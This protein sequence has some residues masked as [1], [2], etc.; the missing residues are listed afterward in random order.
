MSASTAERELGDKQE[1][2]P[3]ELPAVQPCLQRVG[4]ARHLH[5]QHDIVDDQLADIE[6]DDR[7]QRAHQAQHERRCREDA[8]RPPHHRHEGPEVLERTDP[9]LEG[10]GYRQEQPSRHSCGGSPRNAAAAAVG[11]GHSRRSY[12]WQSFVNGA[13]AVVVQGQ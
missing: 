4:L 10:S 8:A 5:Q 11:S 7:Q 3:V 9:F 2:Q 12:T 6:R 1:A 13:R